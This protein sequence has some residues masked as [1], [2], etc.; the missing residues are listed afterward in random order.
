[1]VPDRLRLVLGL[2]LAP[3]LPVLA[4]ADGA[5]AQDAS[6]RRAAVVCT[7]AGHGPWTLRARGTLTRTRQDGGMDYRFESAEQVFGWRLVASR[8]GNTTAEGPGFLHE[9]FAPV[10]ANAAD[11]RQSL[12]ATGQIR[13]HDG[14]SALMLRIGSKCPGR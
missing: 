5:S 13:E 4:A 12:E 7:S 1:M 6:R 14:A 2:I 11:R 3:I 10:A 9:R 8:E